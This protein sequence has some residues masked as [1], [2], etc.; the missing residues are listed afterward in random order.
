[1]E[2]IV[3]IPIFKAEETNAQRVRELSKVTRLQNS[4]PGIWPQALLAVVATTGP[5]V[6]HCQGELSKNKQGVCFDYL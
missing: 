5:T 3:I 6:L 4:N 1:M 2:I